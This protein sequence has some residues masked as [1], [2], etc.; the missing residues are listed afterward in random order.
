MKKIF[1]LIL[2]FTY[3]A[4]SSGAS[5][6]LHECM[7]KL[8]A[9]DLGINNE[10]DN[11]CDKCH[12][13][14]KKQDGCCQDKI[15]VLKAAKD[16]VQPQPAF[17]AVTSF[18]TLQPSYFIVCSTGQPQTTQTFTNPVFRDWQQSSPSFFCCFR[19]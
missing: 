18:V 9:V 10:K 1:L 6:Y 16:Q 14:K 12:M 4:T 5:I 11:S 17:H 2:C 19:I 15:I 7:G 3:L 8:A 13:P